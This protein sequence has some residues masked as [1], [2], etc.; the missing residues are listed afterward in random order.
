MREDVKVFNSRTKIL[1][2]G[3]AGYIGG[4]TTDFLV[5]HGFSVTV[6]DK[7]IYENRYLKPVN[8]IY[9]DIRDIQLLS[10]IIDHFDIIILMAAL[11][12]DPACAVDVKLTYEIN[13][14]AVQ[15][16]CEIIKDQHVIF[17]STCSV[18][19]NQHEELNEDSSVDP[20][21][22]YAQTKLEAEKYVKEV[23]GTIFRLGTIYGLG[24]TYSRIRLDLVVNVL[25]MKAVYN[26]KITIFGGEQ[27]RPLLC[28]KDVA[29]YIEDVIIG[30]FRGTYI[31]A[32]ES[33]TMKQLAHRIE[34]IIPDIT[35]NYT[36]ILF[37]DSRN[38]KVSTKKAD[39][40][41]IYRPLHTI[42]SE[43]K[44]MVQIFTEHR[45]KNPFTNEYHN[46]DFIFDHIK[47]LYL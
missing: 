23:N 37:E 43:V 41:L 13:C 20:L 28:V 15:N 42:E 30:D 32:E 1:I 14:K 44:L 35:I 45:I 47:E 17:L 6:Y 29:G 8:F 34:R 7:L 5:D 11:V 26:Q 46:G 21:S 3:G 12:G 4:Y 31:L 10:T 36:D 18:Y 25:T 33:I 16:I 2:I 24:D 39:Y 22:E 27:Y 19:G 40:N 9:G 38:Y